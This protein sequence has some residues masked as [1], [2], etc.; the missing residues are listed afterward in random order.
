MLPLLCYR[1]EVRE[2]SEEPSEGC[3]RLPLAFLIELLNAQSITSTSM[4]MR[5]ST[6]TMVR[7]VVIPRLAQRAEGPLAGFLITRVTRGKFTT[8]CE[9]LRRLRG[10]G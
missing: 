8:L 7:P 5:M 6:S 3:I 1:P 2:R 10:S 4:R 9:V